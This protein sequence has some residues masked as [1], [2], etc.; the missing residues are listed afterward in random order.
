VAAAGQP[1]DL[2]MVLNIDKIVP[3]PYFRSYWIQQN[4]SE[5]K[6]YSAA[7]SDLNLSRMEY[8]EDRVLLE[9]TPSEATVSEDAGAQAVAALVPL[10]PAEAGIYQIQ[11]RPSADATVALLETK[12]LAPHIGPGVASQIAP[13]VDL[14]NGAAGG[15]GDMETRID[16]ARPEAPTQVA[17]PD[18]LK[19]L[20][21]G[22]P[23]QA[24]MNVQQTSVGPDGVFVRIH[25]T[26]VLLGRF[27]WDESSALPALAKAVGPMLT[28]NSLGVNW[29]TQS[30]VNE[31]DGIWDL[32]VAV[33][34]KYLF[35]S[36][37]S[38]LLAQIMAR[39]QR[40]T[41]EQPATFVAGFNH[42]AARAPYDLLTAVLDDQS[43]PWTANA[44]RAPSFLSDNLGSLSSAL[45]RVSSEKL[46]V[47][48]SGG[49]VL[50]T[51]TY[52]WAN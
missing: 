2:R 3:S 23:V 50:Q 1:G 7:I 4:I 37:D 30:G 46:V 10:V 9:K 11:S 35:L 14:S 33:R 12:L 41:T 43:A 48:H 51:V 40:K 44:G 6:A 27:D 34:G 15:A 29:R 52:E 19:A 28:T 17:Q 32:S 49:K 31:L 26:V 39:L 21:A 8:R 36:D 20:L 13:Q 22:N 18:A 24:A 5:M 25:T 16:Q 47:R 45:S 38:S 42:A